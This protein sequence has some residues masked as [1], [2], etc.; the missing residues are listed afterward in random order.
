MAKTTTTNPELDAPKT[1]EEMEAYFAA[2]EKELEE[3]LKELRS[4]E[5]ALDA[6]AQEL[7]VKE[8][9]TVKP[10]EDL[11]DLKRKV[12]V[13][14]PL[15]SLH[16]EPMHVRVNDYTCIIKRGVEVQIPYFVY[17]AIKENEDADAK[18]LMLLEDMTHKFTRKASEYDI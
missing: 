9:E 15:D 2:K 8:L 14:L 5:K 11:S 13:T 1:L 16:K 18:T 7:A 12:K 6:K 4:Q 3:R 10:A 17:L